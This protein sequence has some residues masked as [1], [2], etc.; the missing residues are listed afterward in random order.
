MASPPPPRPEEDEGLRGCELYVQRHGLQQVLRDCVVH[1]CVARPERPMRF[2][3][4]HF[5]ALEKVSGSAGHRLGPPS[6][7]QPPTPA[8]A[9]TWPSW[10]L[11][12]EAGQHP[13]SSWALQAVSPE[14]PGGGRARNGGHG[15]LGEREGL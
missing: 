11:Q 8:P 10:A 3:R 7:V 15:H 6:C 1:L 9:R 4:E 12:R 5:E 14:G 2:L 13:G